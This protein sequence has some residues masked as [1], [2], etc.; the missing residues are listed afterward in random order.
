MS[1]FPTPAIIRWLQQEFGRRVDASSLAF[2][3]IVWGSLMVYEGF[4]KLDHAD[5]VYSPAYFHFTYSLFPFVEPL[6]E[7]WM[8]HAEI[9]LLIAA[10]VSMTLGLGF[11][12]AAL[13]F[14]LIY[15]HLFL[16]ERIYYNNHF[17]LTILMNFLFSFT[18]ADRIW[19]LPAWWRRAPWHKIL[20]ISPSIWTWTC[21]WTRSSPW[22]WLSPYSCPWTTTSPSSGPS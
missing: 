21:L 11:R 19:S 14:T 8:V 7:V 17:Y 12:Y 1:E 4:R 6:P 2:F 22:A 16:V 13:L 5:G 18:Q 15:S 20:P 3:R 9:G 10:A